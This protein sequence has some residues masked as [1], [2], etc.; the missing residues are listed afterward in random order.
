MAAAIAIELKG[1]LGI[2]TKSG[3]QAAGITSSQSE[4]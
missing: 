1:I 2:M 3:G 4:K